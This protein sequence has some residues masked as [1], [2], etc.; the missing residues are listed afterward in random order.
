MDLHQQPR[1]R[2]ILLQPLGLQQ[3]LLQGAGLGTRLLRDGHPGVGRLLCP[4]P[5]PVSAPLEDL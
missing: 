5:Q 3:S 1:G 2:C 4:V